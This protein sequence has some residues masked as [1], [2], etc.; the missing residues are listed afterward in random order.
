MMNKQKLKFALIVELGLY[1]TLV[2]VSYLIRPV[3]EGL[4][5]LIQLLVTTLIVVPIMVWW[6][7]P[8]IKQFFNKNK[9]E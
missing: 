3:T 4:H 7:I 6:M 9:T 2:G 5:L 8:V 1:P